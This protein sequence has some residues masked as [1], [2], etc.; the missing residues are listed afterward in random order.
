MAYYLV[1]HTGPGAA[2]WRLKQRGWVTPGDSFR[3]WPRIGMPG[4]LLK[5]PYGSVGAQGDDD[6]D[7][8]TELMMTV[9]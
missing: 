1:V 2:I 5:V 7:D 9:C 6:D 8:D 3:D 4:E